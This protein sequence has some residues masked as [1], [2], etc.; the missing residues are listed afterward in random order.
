LSKVIVR[1]VHR[2]ARVEFVLNPD[3]TQ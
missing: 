1:S 3:S 2:S